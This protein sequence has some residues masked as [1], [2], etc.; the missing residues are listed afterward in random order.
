MTAKRGSDRWLGALMGA[1]L[2]AAALAGCAP[3]EV[4]EVAPAEVAPVDVAPAEA[5]PAGVVAMP[6]A[7]DAE[8]L[9]TWW[10]FAGG[11]GASVR[12]RSLSEALRLA[13]SAGEVGAR[14]TEASSG[15]PP[16]EHSV[17]G[18][19]IGGGGR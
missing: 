5:A 4:A 8:G 10:L 16:V 12:A 19:G 1:V 11:R 14:L 3:A 15:A 13:N 9:R 17:A 7:A 2:S 18:V 6:S